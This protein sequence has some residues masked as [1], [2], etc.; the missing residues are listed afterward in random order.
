MSTLGAIASPHALATR[1]GE[2][3]LH[4]GGTAVDAA[5]ATC[6]V[7]TVVYPHMCSIGGDIQA[8]LA[9]PDGRTRALGGSGAAAA[10]ASAQALRGTYASMPIHGAHPM[11]VPGVIA[12]WADLHA[13]G[14]RLPWAR[15][16]EDAISLARDGVPVRR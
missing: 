8:L 15:L 13:Q 6:A 9:L 10:A 12:A 7:L 11:T 5:V 2:R 16:L 4:D 1:A 3:A 14:G